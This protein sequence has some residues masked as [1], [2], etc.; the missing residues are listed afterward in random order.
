MSSPSARPAPV[1]PLLTETRALLASISA[2]TENGPR[3]EAAR[4][5]PRCAHVKAKGYRCGSPALRE[6][7]YCFYHERVHNRRFEDGLPPLDDANAIQL[8]VMQV[9]DGLHRG[10]IGTDTARTYF[11]GLRVAAMLSPNVINADP[12][13][14][15]LE[16]PLIEKTEGAETTAK[17]S[18]KPEKVAAMAAAAGD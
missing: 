14:V 1:N 3:T 16:E 15:V 5:A 4:S 17:R 8:A 6:K 7:Q 13:R 10:K 11:C 9:L 18:P 2:L 12:D